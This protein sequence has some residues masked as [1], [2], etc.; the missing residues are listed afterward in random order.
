M[1]H[2]KLA[3]ILKSHGLK[4]T[5]PRQLVFEALASHGPI[6]NARLG[7]ALEADMDRATVYRTV[8]LFE[9]IGIAR[10]VW[11]GWKSQ[12]ELSEAFV[13]HHHHALCRVCGRHIEMQSAELEKVLQSITVQLGF[14]LEDHSVDLMGVCKNCRGI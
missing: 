3:V 8:E 9:G 13:P 10:R 14:E 6:S 4:L 1:K 11:N 5:R 12:I 7:D 2:E